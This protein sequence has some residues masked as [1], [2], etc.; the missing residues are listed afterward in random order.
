MAVIAMKDLQFNALE[1]L[2]LMPEAAVVHDSVGIVAVNAIAEP[3]LLA[4]G[5]LDQ[6]RCIRQEGRISFRSSHSHLQLNMASSRLPGRDAWLTLMTPLSSPS[7]H[8]QQLVD[9]NPCAFMVHRR[10]KPLFANPAFARLFDFASVEQVL[11]LDSL[12]RIIGEAHWPEAQRNYDTL[13]ASGTLGKTQV[14]EHH[15]INGRSLH[16]H[17]VDFVLMWDGEPAVCTVVSN[18]SKEVRQL[19]KLRALALTDPLTGLSN[20]RHFFDYS[21]PYLVRALEQGGGLALILMDIDHFKEINDRFGHPFGDRVLGQF[22]QRLVNLVEEEALAARIGG[23]EFA[24]LMPLRTDQCVQEVAECLCRQVGWT[25]TEQGQEV[26][27]AVSVG[28]TAWRGNQDRLTDMYLRADKALY[29]AKA[30]GRN[31]S[32]STEPVLVES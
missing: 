11:E 2:N 12:R 13:M 24:L 20:R 16:A 7:H 22:G 29:Q 4:S 8:Y 28:A 31:R 25:Q 17:L 32:C 18:V 1:W 14:V 23:E 15:T 19:E 30:E 21:E 9:R 3:L 6:L 27:V 26:R 10:F 5:V